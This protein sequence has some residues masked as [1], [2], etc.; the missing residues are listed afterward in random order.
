[1]KSLMITST[2]SR[3]GKTTFGLGLLLN[4]SGSFGYFKPL[5]NNLSEEGYDKDI[6]LFKR[7]L[8][9][10]EEPQ[11]M[12][13]AKLDS[14]GVHWRLRSK[15]NKFKDKDLVLIESAHNLS[16][17]AFLR[18]CSACVS[19][20]LKNKALIVAEGDLENIVDKSLLGKA[21]F[22]S[23]GSEVLG[24]VINKVPPSNLEEVEDIV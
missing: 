24:V 1:M 14:S 20:I 23:V 10:E 6:L 7:I 15:L 13:V 22:S 19:K 8:G 21:Y 12:F 4:F 18:L 5:A 16:Y 2:K 17:G 9:L 3:A 11:E